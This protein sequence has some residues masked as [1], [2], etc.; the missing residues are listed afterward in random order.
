MYEGTTII[1]K[2][3]VEENWLEYLAF[4]KSR[5]LEEDARSEKVR[6]AIE[7]VAEATRNSVTALEQQKVAGAYEQGSYR[8]YDVYYDVSLNSFW[9]WYIT[10]KV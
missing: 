8:Y 7:T 3:I 1:C 6:K 10:E 2:E 4:I 5:A 9:N